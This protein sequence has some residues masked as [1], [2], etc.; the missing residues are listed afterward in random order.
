MIS[1]RYRIFKTLFRLLPIR[2]L[3][4]QPEDKLL[5]AM[6]KIN[7]RQKPVVLG[8]KNFAS[9]QISFSSERI[10]GK[11]F[12]CTVLRH[13]R[14]SGKAILYLY[15]GGMVAAPP[16]IFFYYARD[17]GEAI[18]ADV[19]FPC[20]PLCTE[21]SIADSIDALHN[22]YLQMLA[23][24]GAENI[25]FYGFSS[26]ASL[27][28]GMRAY[29]AGL[30]MPVDS[31]RIIVAVSPGACPANAAEHAAVSSLDKADIGIPAVFLE[32]LRGLLVHGQRDVPEY[33]VTMD[34]ADFSELPETYIYYGSDEVLLAKKTFI[35]ENLRKA[36]VKHVITVAEGMCHCYP[37][38][39]Y[40]PE[41]K[42]AWDE[43][44]GILKHSLGLAANA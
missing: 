11:S 12:D 36:N 28:L 37:I 17:L 44:V 5:R 22:L 6:R 4:S 7:R 32:T 30:S 40:F 8:G 41:G 1:K 38:L 15:G 18:G 39:R 9:K 10:K 26:G 33:M 14:P 34:G 3:L 35:E 25:A 23:E 43:I 27:A 19:W 16:R 31:P 24:Y 13:K 20:Y 2:S 29:S 42:Q 21:H